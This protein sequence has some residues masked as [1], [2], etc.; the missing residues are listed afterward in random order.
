[1]F[2]ALSSDSDIWWEMTLAQ[3]EDRLRFLCAERGK[4]WDKM[5]EEERETF[6]DVLL[7][8]KPVGEPTG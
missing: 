5:S 2:S 6:V 1:L 3:G 4:N 8:E 7:H